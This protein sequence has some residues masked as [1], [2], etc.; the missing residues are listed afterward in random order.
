MTESTRTETRAAP[1]AAM[2]DPDSAAP[3]TE[4][5]TG[6]RGVTMLLFCAAVFLSAFLLF[7]VQPLIGKFILPWFGASPGVWTTCMLF[8]QIVLLVGYAYAHFIVTRLSARRQAVTHICL[9][10]LAVLTLPITPAEGWQPGTE[11]EPIGRILLILTASVGAPLVLLSSTG[12]L[13][14][15]KIFGCTSTQILREVVHVRSF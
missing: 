3:S 2:P 15:G 1:Q 14:V 7:Q 4:R 11:D 12:R 9:L 6:D 5:A 13:A 8:F 10:G